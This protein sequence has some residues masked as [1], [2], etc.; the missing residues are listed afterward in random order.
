MMSFPLAPALVINLPRDTNRLA[1]LHERLRRS[2][3]AFDVIEAVDG[4]SLSKEE[5]AASTT[6][7]G[8]VFMTKGM[9][10]C[11]LSH[12]L[13]W[14]EC[15][16]RNEPLIILEDDAAPVSEHFPTL[17]AEALDALSTLDHT[18]DVLLVGALGCVH[19]RCRYGLNVIHG[20]M[21]GCW[22]WPHS[23]HPLLHVPA[24]PFGTHAYVVSPQGARK[25]LDACPR[26]SFHVD[27]AA[28]GVRELRLYLDTDR[29]GALLSKQAPT[30][31]STIGGLPNRAWLPNFTVDSYTSAEFAWAF[32]APVLRLGPWLLTI[33]RSLCST[34]ALGCLAAATGSPPICAVALAWFSLQFVLIQLL[35]VRRWPPSVTRSSW[36]LV[37]AVMVALVASGLAR[38]PAAAANPAT[39]SSLPVRSLELGPT[40]LNRHGGGLEL[41]RARPGEHARLRVTGGRVYDETAL[42][43]TYTFF[44]HVL[45]LR[46]PFTVL[47]DP[48]AVLVP[49]L[50]GKMMRMIR[51]WVDAHAV[52]WD[53]HVQAH[54]ILLTNP[55]VRAIASLVIR[56]FAPPQPIRIVTS[57][58]E[59]TAFAR[60]CCTRPR[61]W[62]KASYADRDQ[63]FQV[64]S[65]A[66]G[67]GRTASG[68]SSD[69]VCSLVAPSAAAWLRALST[70][71]GLNLLIGAPVGVMLHALSHRN[72][73]PVGVCVAVVILLAVPAAVQYARNTRAEGCP[74]MVAFL[75]STF[76]FATFFKA[77][78]AAMRL[79]PAGA[80]ASLSTWL[81]WFL[82][83]PEPRFANDQPVSRS[84][85]E[86]LTRRASLLALKLL[87][88]GVLLSILLAA[89][90]HAP[91]R[92][93]PSGG[94]PAIL[95]QPLNSL[96]HL[97]CIY[98][99][100]SLCL[101]VG[102]LLTMLGGAATEPPFSN[103]LLASRSFREAWGER[104]NRPVHVF[105]KRTVYTPLRRRGVST[106]AAALL[107]FAA[108]GLLHEYNFA[109]LNADAYTPGH[110]M[111]FFVCMGALMLLEEGALAAL[112]CPPRARRVLASLPSPVIA[113]AL[114][115]VVLPLFSPLFARSWLEAG[116]LRAVGE[117]VPHVKCV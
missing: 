62:V 57:E 53:T 23:P 96:L 41:E 22:R 17:L 40:A 45:A 30:S 1:S 37:A 98:L 78:A 83:L 24:R 68:A 39:S 9:I 51:G 12:R 112:P 107:S 36:L 55:I 84:C 26:A 116:M 85:G 61:S 79:H 16:R 89:P 52:Q 66:W 77:I 3:I 54:A 21:G 87:C 47:W 43:S 111:L 10:G 115:A 72:R 6:V 60:E 29:D 103:P 95:V 93:P 117:M 70:H 4:S 104:W 19:P 82:S 50:S 86:S 8:R 48:R 20:L 91:I 71:I 88:L 64:F 32:N 65:G 69:R 59:A 49:R 110:A 18:W 108:S 75:A 92:A 106:S 27:I 28:W 76:G 80:E 109:V 105:L 2:K 31:A 35:K 94:V 46:K 38:A 25:L 101:D 33:G 97:W 99:W 58:A 34:A 11:F 114:Q 7:L 42:V 113:L 90:G 100:A 13:C 5:L 67:G 74:W 63:R 15:V 81:Q 56:L 44:D 14:S 102:A 73:R